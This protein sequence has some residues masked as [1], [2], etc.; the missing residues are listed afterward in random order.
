[1]A[2][3]PF[4]DQKIVDLANHRADPADGAFG[5]SI[6]RGQEHTLAANEQ[7]MDLLSHILVDES[8]PFYVTALDGTV[9]QVNDFYKKLDEAL[10]DV[11]LAPGQVEHVGKYAVPSLKP[12]VEDVLASDTTVRSEEVVHIN[13][14]ERVFLGRHS[15]IRN[16]RKEIIAVAGTYEDVTVQV[17]G[18]EEANKTQARFQDFARA[19]SDWFFECDDN[20]R[21]RSLSDRFTAIVGQPASLFV[22]SKFEQF[23][24]LGENLDGR[25]D[26]PKA[27]QSRKPF[28]EQLFII[29]EPNGSELK[30]H[31]SAVPV[32]DRTTGDFSGYRGVGMDVTSRYEQ[33]E[34][35]RGIRENLESLLAELTRKNMALDIA[36]EQATSA[37][38]AKNEFLAAMSHELRT[39]LNAIIGFAEAFEQQT[40][41]KLDEAYIGYAKDI[42]KSGQH[43]LGLINDIL[44]VAVIESGGLSLK[45]D[46]LSL[47]V[48]IEKAVHMNMEAA[49][50]K[51]LNIDA[52]E[53]VTEAVVRADDRR[54]TQILVNL[55]SNAV[56]FTKEGG[57]IG[58][59]LSEDSVKK[60]VDIT[61]WDTGIG[62]SA[63]NLAHVFEK[64][65]Q[66]KDHIY[67]RSQE[68]TGLGLHISRELARKM[69]GDLTVVSVEGEG[70]RF[71][72]TVPL[73]DGVSADDLDFI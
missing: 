2:E 48:L 21:I 39:P 20:M 4:H 67:S 42:R 19:S 71:T 47:D 46:D 13:G 1:M 30:F 73:A 59:S 5:A 36:S 44:D 58:I 24:R 65:H 6:T 33:V 17:R 51:G 26:G 41:G 22:G 53:V 60:Q 11:S 28:R 34:E 3:K 31:L 61:V 35:A 50:Q 55:L 29:N 70:S 69:G 37:L 18:I 68:G 7:V 23:G 45:I 9:L 49:R 16:E 54:L 15:P 38:R 43:L 25:I 56:K 62:I 10:R 66:V 8:L 14:R 72:V 64:F 40:F 12:V 32:F 57:S 52:L 63:S 27:I